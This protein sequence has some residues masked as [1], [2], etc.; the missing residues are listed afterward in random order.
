[1]LVIFKNRRAS[2]GGDVEPAMDHARL[3]HNKDVHGCKRVL[4]QKTD[5]RQARRLFYASGHASGFRL[6]AEALGRTNHECPAGTVPARRRIG[7][8]NAILSQSRREYTLWVG[9]T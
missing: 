8:S 4:R 1:M 6:E 3:S 5:D 7:I 9:E 2:L